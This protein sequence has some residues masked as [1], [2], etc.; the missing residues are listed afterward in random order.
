MEISEGG[1][2]SP[3]PEPS[4]IGLTGGIGSG[5]T[6]VAKIIEK[7]GFPVYYSDQRAKDLIVQDPGV[8]DQIIELLGPESYDGLG[9]YNRSY[10]STLVFNDPALLEK[11]NS[12]THPAVRRDFTQWI[13]RQNSKIVFKESALLFEL[14]LDQECKKTIL[15][16]AE[17]NLRIKRVMDRDQKTYRE[18]ETIMDKQMPEKDKVR[19]TVY[20]IYNNGT[21]EELETETNRVLTKLIENLSHSS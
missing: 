11:L 19:K 10:V 3:D 4:I 1:N 21:F 16:T 13:S 18:V 14:G 20:I 5:K 8:K 6:A 17:D 12:I 7:A 2:S 9:Q 15:V